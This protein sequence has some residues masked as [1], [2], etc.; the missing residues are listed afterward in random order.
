MYSVAILLS[1]FNGQNYIKDLLNSLQKQRLVYLTIFVIDD[2][3]SDLTIQIL[4]ES[5]LNI[6]ILKTKGFKDPVK[7]F[8]NLL[9]LVPKDYDYYAFCDQDDFWLRNKL[10][11]SIY[12]LKK[13]NA[14]ISGS[15]TYI[16]NEF[17]KITNQSPQ[18]KKKPSFKNALVQ[19]IAGGNT[20]VWTNKFQKFILNLPVPEPSSHD[21]YLYQTA[22]FFNFKFIYIKKSLILYRQH[23]YNVVGANL[24]T[25]NQIK[26][27]Y[28]G[29]SGR[30]KQWHEINYR[31][32][33][34]F[35]RLDYPLNNQNNLVLEKF[36]YFRKNNNIFKSLYGILK[37]GVFRQT[38][39]GQ[40]MLII[41]ILIKKF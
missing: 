19:S 23:P 25:I 27:I 35:S 14:D 30:Y 31:Y 33:K 11:Y 5:K 41:A 32:L 2:S 13:N 26:R 21:W 34:Q 20:M 6:K 15:R 36:N 22:T 4:K 38:F 9:Y 28:F 1:T 3:S 7:N 37:L 12:N 16:T 40:I 39:K 18:F 8:I 10:I 17:L 24:G 29:L